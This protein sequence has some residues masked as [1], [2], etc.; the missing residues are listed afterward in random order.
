M[1]RHSPPIPSTLLLPEPLGA[2]FE[3]GDVMRRNGVK[4]RRGWMDLCLEPF[5]PS[6]DEKARHSFVMFSGQRSDPVNIPDLSGRA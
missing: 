6:W 5:D 2:P 4:E 3:V 1:R